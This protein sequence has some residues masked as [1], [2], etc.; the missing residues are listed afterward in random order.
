LKVLPSSKTLLSTGWM[1]S[2]PPISTANIP[3]DLFW[4]RLLQVPSSRRSTVQ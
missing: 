1:T 2:T 3:I 4:V